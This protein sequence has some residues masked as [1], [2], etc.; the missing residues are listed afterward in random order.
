MSDLCKSWWFS[1][2]L[3]TRQYSVFCNAQ[4]EPAGPEDPTYVLNK[5]GL[6]S[7]EEAQITISFPRDVTVSDLE[8]EMCTEGKKNKTSSY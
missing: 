6:L 4:V 3:Y 2:S 8:I 7:L 5:P 1:F